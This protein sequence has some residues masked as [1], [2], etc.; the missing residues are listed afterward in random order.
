MKAW[1]A[2][3][4]LVLVLV[5]GTAR[6]LLAQGL[7]RDAEVEAELRL[8]AEP[9]FAAAGL[10]PESV[11][12]YMIND[13]TLNAFVAGCF[14]MAAGVQLI[15]FGILSR[16]YAAITGLLPP[17]RNSTWLLE[18]VHTDRLIVNAAI[19]LAAG[20]AYFGY[21]VYAWGSVGFGNLV[22]PVIPRVVVLGLTL[23]TIGLQLFFS[24][25]LL[26]VLKIPVERNRN[27]QA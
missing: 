20:L 6:P 23:I 1:R 26:G 12:I 9:I 16:Y 10:D 2:V 19:C 3:L 11:R 18:N 22:A 8:I 15:T 13:P 7:I 5:G 14:M 25:F 27:S 21:A 17:N 4:V 24:G